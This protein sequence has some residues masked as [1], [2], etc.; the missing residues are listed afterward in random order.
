MRKNIIFLVIII[1]LYLI[2]ALILSAVYGPSFGFL[3]GEDCWQP[4]GQGG[5]IQHGHPDGP[6]PTE[7]SVNVPV[8]VRYLPIF[9]PGLVLLLFLFTPLSK[10][11]DTKEKAPGPK[12]GEPV[13]D[14]STGEEIKDDK[15]KP[16]ADNGFSPN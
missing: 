13:Y 15:D 5:W 4:D 14:E 3:S 12:P 7:P 10:I 1:L 11:L 16:S 2:P 6:A 9:L 8:I